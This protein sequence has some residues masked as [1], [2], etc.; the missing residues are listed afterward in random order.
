MLVLTP[1]LVPHVE[2]LVTH[3]RARTINEENLDPLRDFLR[4]YG[5]ARGR[6]VLDQLQQ[7][8][9]VLFDTV[10]NELNTQLATFDADMRVRGTDLGRLKTAILLY[11][12]HL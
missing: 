1:D 4:A 11:R 9:S 7:C 12:R 3:L 8:P 6:D 5:V 10:A 2:E